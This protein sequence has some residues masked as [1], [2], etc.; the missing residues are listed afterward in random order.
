M[1]KAL[2]CMMFIVEGVTD[3]LNWFQKALHSL[4]SDTPHDLRP[5][6]LFTVR[7]RLLLRR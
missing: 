3:A 1:G 4:V 6:G 7:F 2:F 5:L